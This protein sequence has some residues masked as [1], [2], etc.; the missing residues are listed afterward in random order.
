[1]PPTIPVRACFVDLDGTMVDTA[2]DFSAAINVMLA[3]LGAA[4]MPAERIIGFVGKGTEHLVRSVL[5]AAHVA[6][7]TPQ[8]FNDAVDHYQRAYADVNG[9]HTSLYPEVREGLTALRDAGLPL[10]CIT[11]KP[12]RFAV[13]LLEQYDL[14][15]LFDL[16]YGGDS[17]P[18]R[19]PD[20]MPLLKA[21]ET[22]GV[23]PAETVLIGDSANDAQAAR[24]AGCRVLTVPYG[25][26]HGQAIQSVDSDGIVSS[27][28]G[29]ARAIL[30]APGLET[31]SA[32]S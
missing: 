17:W 15:P 11:N 2:G 14:L 1:M 6:P 31:Y 19:K 18:R 13:Q 8:T 30:P 12:R 26:N 28:L 32:D 22:F 21:C 7:T 5:D 4:P 23:T 9:R 10:A 20:P 24:A 25:Y 3:K 27:L 16:V 29:A